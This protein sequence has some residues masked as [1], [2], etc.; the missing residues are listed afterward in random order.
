[1]HH[2]AGG[3][4]VSRAAKWN[5]DPNGTIKFAMKINITDP[6]NVWG[7]QESFVRIGD[8]CGNFLQYNNEYF[9]ANNNPVLNNSLDTWATYEIP[10]A[11]GD[12]WQLTNE[13]LPDLSAIT[14]IEFNVDVWEWGYELWLD[15]VRLPI[16]PTSASDISYSPVSISPN[17]ASE[18]LTLNSDVRLLGKSWFITSSKG[19]L[20]QKG[21]FGREEKIDV[22]SLSQGLY[23]LSI[24]LNEGKENFKF[25]VIK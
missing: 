19:D 3:D 9:A 4:D 18:E 2:F 11:G 20:I 8:A 24:P 12:T 6:N 7:V 22:G 10:L 15:D 21:I 23:Y 17:P 14:Y 16:R 13:G 25:I 1:L 5:L